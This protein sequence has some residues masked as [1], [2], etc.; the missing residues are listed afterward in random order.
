M[1]ASSSSQRPNQYQPHYA[2]P[3]RD[4]RF[5]MPCSP[6]TSFA[7]FPVLT[8]H[9]D[10]DDDDTADARH[11]GWNLPRDS[12]MREN[13]LKASTIFI[14][15]PDKHKDCLRLRRD[16]TAFACFQPF[17]AAPRDMGDEA[18][19]CDTAASQPA[20]E[21]EGTPLTS[22]GYRAT[23]PNE[24]AF[25]HHCGRGMR[26]RIWLGWGSS[27]KQKTAG[28]V[29]LSYARILTQELGSNGPLVIV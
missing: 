6:C 1:P 4:S 26:P 17:L 23:S 25:R 7:A 12:L 14:H 13:I 27:W 3:F 24:G 15:R 10:D 9:F 22:S 5:T 8:G 29:H 21:D 2:F 19:P 16:S 28:P 11:H 20:V 18:K